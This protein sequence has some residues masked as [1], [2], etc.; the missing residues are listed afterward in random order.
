MASLEFLGT[1]SHFCLMAPAPLKMEKML[2]P[3]FLVLA[4]SEPQFLEVKAAKNK[5]FFKKSE[6]RRKCVFVGESLTTEVSAREGLLQW[7]NRPPGWFS[8]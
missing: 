8:D 5:L 7:H 1:G 4:L 2:F 6:A 3:L